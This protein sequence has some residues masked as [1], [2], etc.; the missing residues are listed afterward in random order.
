M[1]DNSENNPAGN[2]TSSPFSA[3]NPGARLRS[4]IERVERLEEEKKNI[5][6]DIRDVYLEAKSEGYNVKVLRKLVALRKKKP[7]E[8]SEEEALLELYKSTIG[9]M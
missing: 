2:A 1:M 4:L 7:A 5:A 8:V 9:M 6:D 3:N